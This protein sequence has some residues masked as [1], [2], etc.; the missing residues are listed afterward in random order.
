MSLGVSELARSPDPPAWEDH[1]LVPSLC[2]RQKSESR[3]PLAQRGLLRE[4]SRK[5][6]LGTATAENSSLSL[7]DA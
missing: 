5:E 4:G 2:T 6:E 3:A 7:L 1:L